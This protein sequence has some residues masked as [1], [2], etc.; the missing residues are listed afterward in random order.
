M[1]LQPHQQN[2]ESAVDTALASIGN[3]MPE[4][5]L[6]GRILTRL[7]A[8]RIQNGIEASPAMAAPRT[9]RRL[10]RF[11]TPVLGFLSVGLVCTVI[12]GGSVRY[13]RH[14]AT[15]V[16][17]AVPSLSSGGMG[18]ASAMQ[19]AAPSS[20]L[21]ADAVQ[22]GRASHHRRPGRARIAPHAHQHAGI[23]LPNPQH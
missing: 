19:P 10:P 3:A 4:A 9:G 18:T 21:A 15:A 7:A 14:R 17:P 1:I 8:A 12:I 6:E 22:R 23:A 13:S 11:A 16:V 5:G 2:P 20:P